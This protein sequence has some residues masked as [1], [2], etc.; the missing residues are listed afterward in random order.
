MRSSASPSPSSSSS[1][2]LTPRCFSMDVEARR[3]TGGHCAKPATGLGGSR[4]TSTTTQPDHY[5]RPR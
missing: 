1:A 2:T 4:D 3:S 5:N